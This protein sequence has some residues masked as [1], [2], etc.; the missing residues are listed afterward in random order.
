M[1]PDP[2]SLHWAVLAAFLGLQCVLIRPAN[3]QVLFDAEL[4]TLPKAQ[5]WIFAAIGTASNYLTNTA[6]VLD[7][8]TSASTYG[9]WSEIAPTDLNRTNGFSLRFTARVDIEAHSSTNRAGFSVIVLG[10][11]AHGL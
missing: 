4:N 11:D 6:A 2:A 10:S 8:T 3:A 9:G 5:G 7:T 1:R